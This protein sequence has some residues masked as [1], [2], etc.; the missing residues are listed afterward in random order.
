MIC[1]CIAEPDF[2]K[3]I[4]MARSADM[5]EIRLD[6]MD[7]SFHQVKKL[8]SSNENLIATCRPGKHSEPSRIA[9][10]SKAV[11]S[12]AAHVD[13]E[14]E[15]GDKYKSQLLKIARENDCKV[16]ISYHDFERTPAMTGLEKIYNESLNMGADIVKIACQVND[17]N[18]M[19]NLLQVYKFGKNVLSIGMGRFGKLTRVTG[20]YLGAGFAFSASDGS[21]GTAPGQ[22]EY[23]ELKMIDEILN[24]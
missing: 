16:I 7:F 3:C 9:L 1:I 13:I 17:E 4:E 11:E 14:Y 18:D 23:S 15:S 2:D 24:K 8:F 22:L 6:A 12:G 20:M 10:L 21:E 19:I 5:A